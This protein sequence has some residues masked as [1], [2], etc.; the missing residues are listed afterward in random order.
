MVD[1]MDKIIIDMHSN[2]AALSADMKNLKEGQ[3]E[4]RKTV[5]HV[6]DLTIKQNGS[7]KSNTTVIQ[8]H[9]KNHE[10]KEK[11]IMWKVGLLVSALMFAISLAFKY[12]VP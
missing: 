3:N 5:E 2:L 9:R 6:R 4:I 1:N 8:E 12:I 11:I 10:K 7:I